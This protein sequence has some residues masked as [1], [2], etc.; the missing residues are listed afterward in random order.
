VTAA[1]LQEKRFRFQENTIPKPL[2]QVGAAALGGLGALRDFP[3]YVKVSQ[4][5][6]GT[7]YQGSSSK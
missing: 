7:G 4:M 2:A 3:G 1:P 6:Q 5:V